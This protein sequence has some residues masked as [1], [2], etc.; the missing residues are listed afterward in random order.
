M[1]TG[2][3]VSLPNAVDLARILQ[4][5]ADF[6]ERGAALQADV[7]TLKNELPNEW[8]HPS[9]AVRQLTNLHSLLTGCLD[10]LYDAIDGY[11]IPPGDDAGISTRA[12]CAIRQIA[13]V[14]A[15]VWRWKW[16]R[17]AM[18]GQASMR[19]E[20]WAVSVCPPLHESSS[21]RSGLTA[22]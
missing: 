13:R 19:T 4:R 10:S 6:R 14:A 15:R 8:D 21:E 11:L 3:I 17:N 5:I 12:S 2:N 22:A 18:R 20:L 7:A 9:V 1:S 16:R